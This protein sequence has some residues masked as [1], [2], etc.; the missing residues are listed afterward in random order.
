MAFARPKKREP[1]GEAGLFEYAVGLLA[2]RMR[3]ERDLRRL[4][5]AR[6][7]DGEA[8]VRAMD[9]VVVRLKEL[10]YLSDTRFAEDYTRVRKEHEKFGK[11]RVQ[12]DL[13]MKGVGKEL[14]ASTLESAYEDVDEVVLARQYI[15]RKRMKQPSGVNAQKETVRTMNRLLRAGFSSNAI[16]KVL[17]AW[18]LPEEALVGVSEG[19]DDS[20][21]YAEPEERAGDSDSYAKQNEDDGE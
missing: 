5:R 12:Q 11:R 21:S 10:N 6:A 2:R 15:A 7:E 14:V 17:R 13:M 20:D 3:T 4:M 16:F 9:A 8:G 18:D 19:G 1:V